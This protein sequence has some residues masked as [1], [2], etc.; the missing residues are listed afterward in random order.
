MIKPKAR[1]VALKGKVKFKPLLA[2][3]PETAGIKAGYMILK[4]K[5]SVGLHTTGAR[6]EIIIFLEGKARVELMDEP[7]VYLRE[8]QVLYIPPHTK[9]NIK[10]I[11]NK[12]LC[13]VYVVSPVRIS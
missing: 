1:I 7:Q 13:Y 8:K 11:G 10:N 4:P 3:V 5:E 9:H 12:N 6:E 2:G